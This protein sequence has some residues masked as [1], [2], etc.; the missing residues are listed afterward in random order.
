MAVKLSILVNYK[1]EISM[2]VDVGKLWELITCVDIWFFGY[3]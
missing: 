1:S 2:C 3:W